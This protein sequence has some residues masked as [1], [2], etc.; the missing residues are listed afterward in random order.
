MY[1]VQN[2]SIRRERWK[3]Q[4]R[5]RG[6]REAGSTLVLLLRLS[7]LLELE[8]QQAGERAGW[9]P[10]LVAVL[11]VEGVAAFV[12]GVDGALASSLV[13]AIPG[14]AVWAR[15]CQRPTTLSLCLGLIT[16]HDGS[17][18]ELPSL[19]LKSSSNATRSQTYPVSRTENEARQRVHDLF[20]ESRQ[21]QTP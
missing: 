5:G 9:R 16:F 1:S 18:R 17:C 12:E 14:E 6:R 8:A 2:A 7:S 15:A 13:V 4:G 11:P 10:G 3:G 20:F 21:P 19:M